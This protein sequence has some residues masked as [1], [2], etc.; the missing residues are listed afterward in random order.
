MRSG[1]PFR[2]NVLRY[3]EKLLWRRTTIAR[4]NGKGGK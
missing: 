4:L 2:E 3:E 1:S